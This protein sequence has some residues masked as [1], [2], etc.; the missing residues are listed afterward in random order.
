MEQL[1]S[2]IPLRRLA[3]T[4]DVWMGV[5]FVIECDYFTARVLD[6]DGGLQL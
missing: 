1:K 4:D 6:V 2:I 5:R 3:T